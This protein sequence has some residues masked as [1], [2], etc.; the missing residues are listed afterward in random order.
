MKY[1]YQIASDIDRDGLGVELIDEH[2]NVLAEVFRCDK[3]RTLTFKARASDLPFVQVE[4]LIAMA[5][6][7][8]L[9]FEGGVS[10]PPRLP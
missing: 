3:D 2:S 4:K 5:R 1:L 9:A 6:G 10:L 7:E 8:L